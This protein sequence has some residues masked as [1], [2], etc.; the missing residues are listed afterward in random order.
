MEYK[1]PPKTIT[2]WRLRVCAA[3]LLL[4]AAFGVLAYEIGVW[5]LLGT[6]F[7]AAAAIFAAVF[8]IPRYAAGF[9]LAVSPAAITVKR[10][11]FFKAEHILPSLRLVFTETYVTPL[12]AAMKLKGLVFQ[13]ARVRIILPEIESDKALQ[14][15]EFLKAVHEDGK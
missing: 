8:Y 10:G 14:I 6:A 12:S 13:G 5:F 2:L 11:V 15:T 3:A 9:S 1:L 4:C 7:C